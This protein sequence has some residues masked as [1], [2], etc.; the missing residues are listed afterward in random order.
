MAWGVDPVLNARQVPV[1]EFNP[2]QNYELGQKER[3]RDYA[4]K[5]AK[6]R[7]SVRDNKLQSERQKIKAELESLYKILE[8]NQGASMPINDSDVNDSIAQAKTKATVGKAQI[9]EAPLF[10]G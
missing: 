9:Q 7:A 4:F 8:L 1:L 6:A 2:T 10:G 5:V 3:S